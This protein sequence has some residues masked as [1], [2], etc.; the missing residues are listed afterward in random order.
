VFHNKDDGVLM[1]MG[2]RLRKPVTS[3]LLQPR[4]DG[5][6]SAIRSNWLGTTV[7]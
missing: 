2:S 4:E 6:C 7:H 1:P 5:T 3:A